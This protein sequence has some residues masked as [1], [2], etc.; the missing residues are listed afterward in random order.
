MKREIIKKGFRRDPVCGMVVPE[1]DYA[2]VYRSMHFSFCS[3][4]CQERFEETPHLY[5]GYVGQKAPKQ[6]GIEV[7]KKRCLRLDKPLL[8]DESQAVIDAVNEMM[9][10]KEIRIEGDRIWLRYDLLQATEAQ[11]ERVIEA[12]GG[13]LRQHRID[14]IRRSCIHFFEENEAKGMSVGSGSGK[15]CH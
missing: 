8:P 9:G 14:R 6:E 1:R 7:F 5:I 2:V 3:R 12:S 15:S 10:I 11:I 13:V 4:Q